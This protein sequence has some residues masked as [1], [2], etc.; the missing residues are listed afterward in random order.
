MEVV[1]NMGL[2]GHFPHLGIL[3]LGILGHFGQKETDVK[4]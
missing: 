2:L 3:G 1:Y 4:N